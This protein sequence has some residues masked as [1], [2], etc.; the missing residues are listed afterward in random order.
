MTKCKK[1]YSFRSASHLP[2]VATPL[3]IKLNDMEEV[4]AERTHFV[5]NKDSELEYLTAGGI[6]IRGR[7]P[8]TY[9]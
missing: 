2:P 6:K 9:P 8:W 5:K 7:Y 1:I 4:L 3:V